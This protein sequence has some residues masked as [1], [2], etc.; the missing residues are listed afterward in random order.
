M[1]ATNSNCPSLV[2]RRYREITAKIRDTEESNSR[3][4]AMHIFARTALKNNIEW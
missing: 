1:A 3:T 4:A 2:R